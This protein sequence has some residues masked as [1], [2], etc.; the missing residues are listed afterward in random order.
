M[1]RSNLLIVP[2][3]LLA[4][5]LW[6]LYYFE[7]VLVSGN[8]FSVIDSIYIGV[9]S[10]TIF[11]AFVGVFSVLA[12]LISPRDESLDRRL[13]FLLT[14]QKISQNAQ[15]YLRS[16]IKRISAYIEQIDLTLTLDEIYPEKNCFRVSHDAHSLM[17]NTFD[18]EKYVDERF[19]I[20]VISDERGNDEKYG[21]I[22]NAKFLSNFGLTDALNDG[23]I[24]MVSDREVKFFSELVIPPG[25]TT[26]YF[27]NCWI[28]NSCDLPY[29]LWLYRYAEVAKIKI[30]NKTGRPA[31]LKIYFGNE[32]EVEIQSG[33]SYQ[34]SWGKIEPGATP[35]F[36]LL[37][38]TT[39]GA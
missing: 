10:S 35:I 31:R 23:N 5:V 7:I 6:I 18:K 22:T 20:K 30:V 11:F 28:H 8:E 39:Q 14:S 15:D 13:E 21:Q 34:C 36:S 2:I 29:Y 37:P 24:N 12:S 1:N 9:L 17:R 38:G 19:E 16:E 27:L 25:G 3:L 4:I 33:K 32:E 26:S